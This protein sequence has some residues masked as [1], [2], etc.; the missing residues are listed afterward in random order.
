MYEPER[1]R[2]GES[3]K[4]IPDSP[5][6][7]LPDS[8]IPELLDWAESYRGAR[9]PAA[10]AV[11]QLLEAAVAWLR[12]RVADGVRRPGYDARR[13][14]EASRTLAACRKSLAQRN[15]NP[16]MVAERALLALREAST[17]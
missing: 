9:A 10:A 7:R 12:R 14:L 8:S 3:E 13:E 15:A 2:V 16:Q 5:I 17:P 11:G 6:P 4:R 1:L